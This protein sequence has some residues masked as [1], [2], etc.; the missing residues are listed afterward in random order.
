MKYFLDCEFIEGFHKPIS[1]KRRHFID[2]ISIGIVAEDGREYYAISNEF[3]SKDADDWVKKNVIQKLDS[4]NTFRSGLITPTMMVSGP[5]W[6]SNKEIR[7]GILTFFGCKRD[8]L[9]Y[10]APDGVE[11]YGYYSD[12]DWVLFCSLFGRMI[13]LPKGFPMYCKDLKQMMDEKVYSAY[14]NN[15]NKAVHTFDNALRWL[16]EDPRYPRGGDDHN[17]LADAKWNYELYKFLQTL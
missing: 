3:R 17:A 5:I 8:Q 10:R 6:K 11:V 14:I 9:F 12:Y 16:K 1:G 7:N 4:K 15:P 13:D 2:L